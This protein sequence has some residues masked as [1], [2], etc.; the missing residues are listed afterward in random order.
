[1]SPGDESQGAERDSAT[2]KV[3]VLTLDH[4]TLT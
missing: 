1:M 2:T 4:E 3:A